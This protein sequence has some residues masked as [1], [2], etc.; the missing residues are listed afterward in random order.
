MKYFQPYEDNSNRLENILEN[1]RLLQSSS[2]KYV[3]Q[4]SFYQNLWQTLN[5]PLSD[6][7]YYQIKRN[8]C[9]QNDIWSKDM[10]LTH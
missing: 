6:I 5:W 9:N 7:L 3:I 8:L 10:L 1:R 2:S 4:R